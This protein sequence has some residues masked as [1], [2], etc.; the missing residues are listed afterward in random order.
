MKYLKIYE[1]FM[2]S[3]NSGIAADLEAGEIENDQIYSEMDA[4]NKYPGASSI[5][6]YGVEDSQ[7]GKDEILA[8][9]EK[10]FADKEPTMQDKYDFYADLRE[11]GFDG[12]LI[13]DTLGDK[14]DREEDEYSFDEVQNENN[15]VCD[16]CGDDE[17]KEN[18]ENQ[19]NQDNEELDEEC[20][21]CN[22]M[23]CKC[24]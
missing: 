10:T 4:D 6:S 9:W 18:Q 13:F 14:M 24:K 16:P 23:P 22:C 3:R 19:E 20:S 2:D 1:N 21:S 12:M 17:E 5:K 15:E 11:E 8:R 7:F